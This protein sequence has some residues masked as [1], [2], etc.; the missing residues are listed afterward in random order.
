MRLARQ[1]QPCRLHALWRVQCPDM[2]SCTCPNERER[3]GCAGA[4]TK[5][6]L[7][8]TPVRRG[9]C[10][11]VR[12]G[13]YRAHMLLL[14]RM[15]AGGVSSGWPC[16]PQRWT[17]IH[18]ASLFLMHQR[19]QIVRRSHGRCVLMTN[20]TLLA[21][22]SWTMRVWPVFQAQACISV[23]ATTASWRY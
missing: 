10:M 22:S 20:H 18:V 11:Q 4:L 12:L 3:S 23:R 15:L 6:T 21:T 16:Y 14:L 19:R 8:E 7:T 13:C 1:V 17:Q 9:G 2:S 5:T